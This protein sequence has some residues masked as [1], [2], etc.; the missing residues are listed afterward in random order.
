[1]KK[2]AIFTLIKDILLAA[3]F[4]GIIYFISL[5]FLG[6]IAAPG[7]A[8]LCAGVPFGWRWASKIITAV[9]LAGIGIKFVFSLLLGWL[10]IFVVII[11]DI[12]RCFTAPSQK[13][14]N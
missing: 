12:I 7:M 9:S 1:M 6:P 10:A 14:S 13:V 11:G 8:F 3:A 2:T 5:E 4:A